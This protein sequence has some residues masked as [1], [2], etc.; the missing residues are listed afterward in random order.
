M[1]DSPNILD[2]LRPDGKAQVLVSL[3]LS[4]SMREQ[5]LRS[6]LSDSKAEEVMFKHQALDRAE[7]AESQ[8]VTECRKNEEL[9]RKLEVTRQH[10]QQLRQEKHSLE[11]MIEKA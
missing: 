6:D 5:Q 8:Y 2:R 3:V 11:H 10:A 7:Q 4:D 9:T 1:P